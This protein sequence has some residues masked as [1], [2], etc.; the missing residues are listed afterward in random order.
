MTWLKQIYFLDLFQI[1][2]TLI[3]ITFIFNAI[4][5]ITKKIYILKNTLANKRIYINNYIFFYKN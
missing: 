5:N 1:V 4:N 2:R 3:L